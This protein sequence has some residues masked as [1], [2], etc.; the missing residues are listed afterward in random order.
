MTIHY[1]KADLFGE[2]NLH[3]LSV[4]PTADNFA[5]I[6]LVGKA[7]FEDEVRRR[8]AAFHNGNY[9]DGIHMGLL[10]EKWEK[11]NRIGPAPG[12]AGRL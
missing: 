7:G 4:W 5:M 2:L 9:R 10:R 8:E 11:K 6:Q 1:S 12:L 3:W